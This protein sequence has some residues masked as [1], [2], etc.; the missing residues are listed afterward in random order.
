MRDGTAR[1]QDN[2]AA[3]LGIGLPLDHIQSF[4]QRLD[5]L[6]APS[7]GEHEETSPR[8]TWNRPLSAAE[9]AELV[10]LLEEQTPSRGSDFLKSLL[11]DV[12]RQHGLPDA[13]RSCWWEL[14]EPEQV[15]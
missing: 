14:M 13:E 2:R 12:S 11:D 15:N 8:G 5:S 6:D 1:A 10:L 7:G 4:L 3:M 9:I